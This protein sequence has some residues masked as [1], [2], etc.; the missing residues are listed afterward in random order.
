VRV[1][2]HAQTLGTFPVFA[3]FQLDGLVHLGG[4]H[5]QQVL[6]AI[7]GHVGELGAL[8]RARIPDDGL[9]PVEVLLDLERVGAILQGQRLERR[10][11]DPVEFANEAQFRCGG[12]V[13]VRSRRPHSG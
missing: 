6:P 11:I 7:G 12:A 2:D 13:A 10:R 3:R 4:F 5:A 1:S 8:G 9:R